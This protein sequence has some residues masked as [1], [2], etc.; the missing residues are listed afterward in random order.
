MQFL[1]VKK[2]CSANAFPDTKQKHVYWKI[3]K[4]RK[5]FDWLLRLR[6]RKSEIKK[7]SDDVQRNVGMNIKSCMPEII[8]SKKKKRFLNMRFSIIYILVQHSFFGDCF[9]AF[10]SVFY[11]NFSTSIIHGGRHFHSVIVNYCI[12]SCKISNELTEEIFNK[13]I[14]LLSQ[15]CVKKLLRQCYGRSLSILRGLMC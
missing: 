4:V 15:L 10:L 8:F 9:K 14:Y 7:N 11:F 6:A 12:V 13:T 5:I 2:W 1:S 3:C